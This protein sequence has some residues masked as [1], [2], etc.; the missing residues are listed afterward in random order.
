MS[1]D[2]S[3]YL[4]REEEEP[5]IQVDV[6]PGGAACPARPLS[7]HGNSPKGQTCL[8]AQ[9][10]QPW[11]QGGPCLSNKPP[12]EPKYYFPS[13]LNLP[14]NYQ[15]L[16]PVTSSLDRSTG[17]LTVPYGPPLAQSGEVDLVRQVNGRR[18]TSEIPEMSKNAF[19]LKSLI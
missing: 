11:C 3:D 13:V 9:L 4:G 16:V 10:I 15:Y 14:A 6:P 1:Q 17:R 19:Q 7:P 5:V 12:P 2:V 8:S 18:D